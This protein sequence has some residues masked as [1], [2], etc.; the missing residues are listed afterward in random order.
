MLSMDMASWL[1]C[2]MNHI[3]AVFSFHDLCSLEVSLANALWQSWLSHVVVCFAAAHFPQ[4]FRI[5]SS[6]SWS[7]C[8]YIRV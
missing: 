4:V 7:R 2:I 5:K 8:W 1:A 3:A 6:P